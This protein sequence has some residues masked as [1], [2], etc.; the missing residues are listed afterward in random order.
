MIHVSGDILIF[1][2]HLNETEGKYAINLKKKNNNKQTNTKRN[3]KPHT[4]A[5]LTVFLQYFLILLAW[6]AL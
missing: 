5:H 1:N 3:K 2:I 4:V 6:P